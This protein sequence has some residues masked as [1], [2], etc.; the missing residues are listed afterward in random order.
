MC[1]TFDCSGKRS[2]WLDFENKIIN[3]ELE[4]SICPPRTDASG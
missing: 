1:R 3:P 4:E 2:V